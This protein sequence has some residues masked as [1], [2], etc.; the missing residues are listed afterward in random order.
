MNICCI[1]IW[2]GS[3]FGGLLYFF[4]L[5]VGLIWGGIIIV[6]FMVIG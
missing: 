3:F 5:V 2:L 4:I 1:V 6:E